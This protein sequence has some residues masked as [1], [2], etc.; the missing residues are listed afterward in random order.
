MAEFVKV[1][2]IVGS[3]V[4]LQ[5][6]LSACQLT[7]KPPD[8]ANQSSLNYV[9]DILSPDLHPSDTQQVTV[10]VVITFVSKCC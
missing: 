6:L 5:A 3:V 7:T 9:I 10:C 2:F 1:T 4:V 8:S